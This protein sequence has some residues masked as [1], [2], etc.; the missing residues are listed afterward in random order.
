MSRLTARQKYELLQAV[1][2]E[3]RA[4][5]QLW[6]SAD[7]RKARPLELRRIKTLRITGLREILDDYYALALADEAEASLKLRP[8]DP[9]A[10]I[11]A[12]A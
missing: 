8:L 1:L 12:A 5:L 9:P 3:E 6:E 7:P 2:I 10:A 4:Q 11:G